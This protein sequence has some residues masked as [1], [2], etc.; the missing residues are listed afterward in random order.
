[1]KKS[2]F[3]LIV[4]SCLF[5]FGG[6]EVG[7]GA[8]PDLEAP[9]ITI[10]TPE[11]LSNV[12]LDFELGGKCTDNIAVTEVLVSNFVT[13]VTYG[14]ASINK[15]E[16]TWSF[17]M[18]L[19]KA[20]EGE[21]TILV[22]ASDKAGN[23]STKSKKTITLLVDD[24]P[25]ESEDWYL[26]RTG[27]ITIKL[28]DETYLRAIDTELSVNKDLAQNQKFTIHGKISDGMSI[29]STKIILKE[30]GTPVISKEVQGSYTPAAEFTH[31]ELK[32]A[33]AS[34]NTGLHFLCVSYEC[35]DD[36]DNTTTGNA[37]YIIWYPESDKPKVAQ[38][39][40]VNN[41]LTVIIQ[42]SIPVDYFDD[43]QVE[44][45]MIALKNPAALQNITEDDLIGSADNRTQIF[46]VDYTTNTD[47]HKAEFFSGVINPADG[48]RDDTFVIPNTYITVAAQ[49]KIVVCVKDSNDIWNAKIFSVTIK[50]SEQPNI[51]I[52]EPQEN[53]IPTVKPGSD[54]EFDLKGYVLDKRAHEG[55]VKI[56]YIPT[57]G[58]YDTFEKREAKAKEIFS[59]L[60][61]TGNSGSILDYGEGITIAW[62]KPTTDNSF[63]DPTNSNWKKRTYSFEYD[64][65]TS[66][67]DDGNKPK[68]FGLLYTDYNGNEIFK[69]HAIDGD[70]I[71]PKITIQ[72]PDD[73][74]V[75]NY[76]NESLLLQFNG[77]KDTGLGMLESSYQVSILGLEDDYTYKVGNGL[78]KNGDYYQITLNSQT[79]TALQEKV[80]QPTFEFYVKDKLGNDVKDRR[81]VVLSVLPK[82]ISITTDNDGKYK[83]TD[84][85]NPSL[86]F[87]VNFDKEVKIVEDNS[88]NKP[89]LVL[90]YSESD[91]SSGTNKKYAEYYSG[92]GTKAL[93]FKYDIPQNVTA[94]KICCPDT[95]YIE[96]AGTTTIQT[97][98]IGTGNANL[99]SVSGNNLKD[100]VITID[101]V[102]PKFNK[103]KITAG[104]TEHVSKK[105]VKADDEIEAVITATEN[106]MV[107]GSPKLI[108]KSGS[109]NLSF[110]FQGAGATDKE[111]VFVHKVTSS[112]ANG[113]IALNGTSYFSNTDKSLITDEIGNVLVMNSLSLES[114][115]NTVVVDTQKPSAPPALKLNG[116]AI[117]SGNKTVAQTLTFDDYEDDASVY[118]SLNGGSAW[119]PVTQSELTDGI[120][121]P[122]GTSDVC[123][124]QIDIAGNESDASASV[125]LYIVTS[126]PTLSGLTITNANGYYKA[127]DEI[128]I[129]LS[130]EG[131]VYLLTKNAY[132]TFTPYAGGTSRTAYFDTT[133]SSGSKTITAKY[134]ISAN[135]SFTGIKI[136]GFTKGSLKDAYNL[137]PANDIINSFLTDGN[138]YRNGIII[139][140]IKPTL[141]LSGEN[142]PVPAVGGVSAHAGT[143][144]DKFT[145]TLKFSEPVYKESGYITLQRIGAD[146]NTNKGNWAIPAII[147]SDDF[148]KIYNQLGTTDREILMETEGGQGSGAEKLQ[149]NTARPLGPYMKYTHG[150]KDDGSPDQTTRYVLAP[151]YG[152]FGTTGTVKNI[153]DVLAKT[154][155]H[156]HKVDINSTQVTGDGTNTITIT[157]NDRIED[158]QH[159]IL[160]MDGTALRDNAQNFVDAL[161]YANASYDMWSKKVAEPVVRVDRYSHNIG[162][163]EPTEGDATNKYRV[164]STVTTLDITEWNDNGTSYN[165]AKAN[166][167]TK[168]APTGYAKVRIDCETPGAVITFGVDT[169]A[170]NNGADAGENDPPSTTTYDANGKISAIADVAKASITAPSISYSQSQGQWIIIGDGEYDTARKDYV[171]AKATAPTNA[172]TMAD[173]S[174]G[175]EGV[176][177]TV[178]NYKGHGSQIQIQGGTFNG[179]MPSIPGFPLRDAVQGPDSRRYNQNTYRPA[180]ATAD[181]DHYWVTYDI[182]S[183]YSILSVY[184]QRRWSEKYSYGEYGQISTLSNISHYN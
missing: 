131:N 107:S 141:Y 41:E 122:A 160:L 62:I 110:D 126:F 133:S 54:S 83:A 182:I 118:F 121:L 4:L 151:E 8:S 65:L 29:K 123:T 66:F 168:L 73:M 40:A 27:G 98:S 153:R 149:D 163:K 64:L 60:E 42:N 174:I 1:M 183:E 32:D 159:W 68:Y 97:A 80:S 180:T 113:T 43:D 114:G 127:N 33:K 184:N 56:V 135:E 44:E 61:T 49:M 129:K 91:K 119:I 2:W 76:T 89:K 18:H 108:L 24:T 3:L 30:N 166:S 143:T 14:K 178:V 5:V 35:K 71:K 53:T 95:G 75:V 96:I 99:P 63:I 87:K 86:F 139:D 93:T 58:A 34:L 67:G 144:A 181:N 39:S 88:G 36:H 20:D 52:V 13:G 59:N 16:K 37:G 22:T 102:S 85:N 10:L 11:K 9:E 17:P 92:S 138:G 19:T 81:T 179:G 137:S 128:E 157:F 167:A 77:T 57:T 112:S 154:G 176:F 145:I 51:Y 117:T 115:S 21:I 103:I 111:L 6:C 125:H 170:T 78:S 109:S 172:S 158:G 26:E 70:T 124:K 169:S 161:T 132:L 142:A 48:V 175:Y 101:S 45:V 148:I 155:Y 25:P 74:H 23:E 177:K 152:L 147:E 140:A 12:H 120:V 146:K 38:N 94:S 50:D 69:S 46:K 90:Y 130:F 150:I 15:A 162:A 84:E 28:Y 116:E 134:K 136:T 164:V 106:V 104:G 72:S 100:K 156:Q 7:M 165:N 105:Y 55:M 79:L 82:A 171:S 31:G 47:D 173:S